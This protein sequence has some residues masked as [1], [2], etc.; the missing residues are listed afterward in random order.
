MQ[1]SF[2]GYVA[3]QSLTRKIY[4][5]PN[6]PCWT[7]SFACQ[8]LYI[9]SGIQ[10]LFV[11]KSYV[12]FTYLRN[13]SCW[14]ESFLFIITTSFFLYLINP[15]A[16]NIQVCHWALDLSSPQL[17]HLCPLRSVRV[18]NSMLMLASLFSF[19]CIQRYQWQTGRSLQERRIKKRYRVSAVRVSKEI[20]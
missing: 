1:T 9:H 4:S 16:Y 19:C 8:I 2:F 20:S 5:W 18:C 6:A 11:H 14:W 3:Y 12:H 15:A 17:L 7:S 10:P 13:C